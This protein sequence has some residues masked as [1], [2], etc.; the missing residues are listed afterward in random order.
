MAPP[1][2]PQPLGRPPGSG[3]PA[4]RAG[5]F[6]LPA[7]PASVGL[8][9]GHVRGLLEDWD[10]DPETCDNAVL[11]TSELVTN[12]VMHTASDRIVCRLRTDGDRIRI[13]VEDESR[14]PTLPEQRIS[15]PDD[16]GGRGLMLVGVLSSDWG[17]RDSPYG[18]GRIV[19]AELIPEG[20]DPDLDQDPAL[21]FTPVPTLAPAVTSPAPSASVHDIRPVPHLAEGTHPHEPS[22]HP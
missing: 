6:G 9:R 19:W 2:S 8:A 14:G 17:V 21:G 1:S 20:P 10:F 16:Q 11:V 3:R 5:I 15:R 7:A 4:P 18:P 22:A 13:E 12:A